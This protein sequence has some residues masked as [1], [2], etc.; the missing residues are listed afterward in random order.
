MDYTQELV[1][2][3]RQ[4]FLKIDFIDESVDLM[5][6]PD[7]S[8]YIGSARIPLKEVSDAPLTRKLPIINEKNM[9]MGHVEIVL[10]F[11]NQGSAQAL[12]KAIDPAGRGQGRPENM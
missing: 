9:Q 12:A 10:S 7:V 1:E 8:D 11:Y 4:H 6:Q 3:M 2:Y 5:T